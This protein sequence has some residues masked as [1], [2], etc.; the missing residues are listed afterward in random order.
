MPPT[1]NYECI[2]PP[3]LH[4]VA[5][6]SA[7]KFAVF[8]ETSDGA[9]VY[10]PFEKLEEAYKQASHLVSRRFREAQDREVDYIAVEYLDAE[11]VEE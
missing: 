10:I 2:D 7:K 9:L 11:V 3:C 5:D 1:N 6:Y 4:V 8:L